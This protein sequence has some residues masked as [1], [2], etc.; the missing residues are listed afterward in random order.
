MSLIHEADTFALVAHMGQLRKYSNEPYIEHPRRVSTTV[1]SVGMDEHVQAAALLHDVVEDCGVSLDTIT[2]RF[3]T[4]VA[5]LVAIMTDDPIREGRNRAARKKA[6]RVRF[7]HLQG[8][9]AIEA[10]TLKAADLI[11]NAPSIRDNDPSFWGVFKR[12][13]TELQNVL[14]SAH[15]D[16]DDYLSDLLGRPLRQ[17]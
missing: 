11:D 15:P 14:V 7:T 5:R 12:E 6:T 9:E 13:V 1:A 10:H 17:R 3:G 2:D 8:Q 4:K 16:L